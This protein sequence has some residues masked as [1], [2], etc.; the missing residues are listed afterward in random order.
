MK[1]WTPLVRRELRSDFRSVL[2]WGLLAGFVAVTGVV[3]LLLMR[4]AEGGALSQSAL[5]FR[6]LFLTLPV[7]IALVSLRSF[8]PEFQ[9]GTLELLLTSPLSEQHILRAKWV[10]ILLEALAAC[11]LFTLCTS[12]SPATRLPF[13]HHVSVWG[14]MFLL[15]VLHIMLWASITLYAALMFKAQSALALLAA[16]LV[17]FPL[18]CF[19]AGITPFVSAT[20]YLDSLNM[21]HAIQ[22]GTVDSRPIVLCLSGTMLMLF[23]ARR[24]L[25]G[26]RWRRAAP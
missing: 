26:F 12:F 9:S 17:T 14:L 16:L 1:L 6:A 22:D 24:H 13:S 23:L 4:S 21:L 7:Y 15:L 19:A 25:E 2:A 11:A 20:G 5:H 3:L 10:R 8:A 18:G